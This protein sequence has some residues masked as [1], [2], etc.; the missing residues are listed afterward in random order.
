MHLL[1]TEFDRPEVT[2]CGR[3]DVEIYELTISVC[4]LIIQIVYCHEKEVDVT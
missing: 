1:M 3:Q 2:P 4:V